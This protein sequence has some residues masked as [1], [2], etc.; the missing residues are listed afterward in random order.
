MTKSRVWSKNIFHLLSKRCKVIAWC[1]L[2]T[3]NM[4]LGEVKI[5]EL[6]V[7]DWCVGRLAKLAHTILLAPWMEGASKSR[8]DTSR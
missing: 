7:V 2:G 5:D 3:L 4:T 1:D 6:E 8:G